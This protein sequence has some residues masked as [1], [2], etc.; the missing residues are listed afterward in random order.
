M[1]KISNL[2]LVVA[3]LFVSGC[4]KA[5]QE[6]SVEASSGDDSEG[7]VSLFDGKT[8]KG[9]R[10]YNEAE[11]E[12]VWIVE[13]GALHLSG[14]PEG[15]PHVNLIT[16]ATYDD[17]E[18]SFEWKVEEGTN[19][20]VMFHVGEGPKEPYLTGPEYQVLDNAGFR[21]GKGEPVGPAEQSASHYSIEP[22]AS[23]ET[24]PVGEWNKGRLVVQGD[25]VEYWLNGVKTTEYE[26]HS[27]AW[28]EQIA[29]S[30]F[31]KW[32]DFATLGQG[33]IG[34]QDHGHRVWFRELKIKEQ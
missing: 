24:K 18:L 8:L 7:W 15:S 11:T 1:N 26:M 30:K 25:H 16:E 22:A 12:G 34:L 10:G 17:F 2:V 29:A 27:P 33:H 32:K 6:T 14:Q 31:S 19:S 9:W 13:E 20:G 23:D 3:I 28:D 21:T 5:Q 4:S